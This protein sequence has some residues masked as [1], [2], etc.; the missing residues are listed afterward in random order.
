MQEHDLS[1]CTGH[2]TN[3]IIKQFHETFEKK[4]SIKAMQIS[5]RQIVLE[6]MKIVQYRKN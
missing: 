2:H 6:I 4:Y 3:N 5:F 1:L